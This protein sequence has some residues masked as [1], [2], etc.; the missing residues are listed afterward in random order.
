VEQADLGS[1]LQVGTA[2]LT[3]VD[4]PVAGTT[5]TFTASGV[6]PLGMVRLYWVKEG[7]TG[8]STCSKQ[9]VCLDLAG[10][11]KLVA[12]TNADSAGNATMSVL[13]PAASLGKTRLYQAFVQW[14]GTVGTTDVVTVD[15]TDGTSTNDEPPSAPTFTVTPTL[16]RSDAQLAAVIT[17]PGVDPDGDTVTNVVTWKKGGVTIHTG[18][19]L[20]ASLTAR[21]EVWT[22]E[23]TATDGTFT[24]A[25]TTKTVTIANAIPVASAVT[26]TPSAPTAGQALTCSYT[27]TDADSD[28]N[29]S[30]VEWLANGLLV[31]V[32]P[33]HIY[34]GS[35]AVTCEVTPFDGIEFGTPVSATVSGTVPPSIRWRPRVSCS[36]TRTRALSA[37]PR[38]R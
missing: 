6:D 7:A 12:S 25:P 28:A 23:A 30:T 13:L 32:G 24:S 10:K 20:D 4:E 35:G 14:G 17:D 29:A 19:T 22:V 3:L 5:V 31:G 27:F 33:T 37:R 38:G 18:T 36:G 11:A 16:A 21:N 26:I 9:G 8:S 34:N 2:D 15:I 1:Q